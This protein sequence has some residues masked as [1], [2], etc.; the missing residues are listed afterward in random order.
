[1]SSHATKGLPQPT[2]L[3][4]QPFAMVLGK[5]SHQPA[6]EFIPV[7]GDAWQQFRKWEASLMRSRTVARKARGHQHHTCQYRRR[8]TTELRL[9]VRV[10][11]QSCGD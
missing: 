11:R 7:A 2:G 5:L 1:M 9:S 3:F 4:L 6:I 10:V 8:F